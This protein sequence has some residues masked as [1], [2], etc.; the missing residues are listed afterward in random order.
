MP[1]PKTI[2]APKTLALIDLNKLVAQQEELLGPLIG[3]GN[4]G[5][6][7][8]LTVDMAE[9]PPETFAVIVPTFAGQ[10][11]V[12]QGSVKVCEGKVFITSQLIDAIATR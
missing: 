5:N 10:A 11:V 6:Q 9:D 8:L 3:I 7:T 2:G 12:P 1:T 4:D